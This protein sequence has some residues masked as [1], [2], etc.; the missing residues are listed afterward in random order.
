MSVLVLGSSLTVRNNKGM[1][2]CD[3]CR[4]CNNTQLIGT[5]DPKAPASTRKRIRVTLTSMLTAVIDPERPEEAPSEYESHRLQSAE[6]RQMDVD[7]NGAGGSSQTVRT[8]PGQLQKEAENSSRNGT[9]VDSTQASGQKEPKADSQNSLLDTKEGL[10]QLEKENERLRREP[11]CQP[12]VRHAVFLFN[13]VHS[14]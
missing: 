1:T 6:G 10:N 11:E 2:P 4:Y 9:E 12:M 3:V 14:Q 13:F 7:P 5:L 8:C